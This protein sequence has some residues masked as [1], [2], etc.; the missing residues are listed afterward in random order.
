MMESNAAAQQRLISEPSSPIQRKPVK[1]TLD[2]PEP[3][4]VVNEASVI[5]VGSDSRTPKIHDVDV[6]IHQPKVDCKADGYH[7]GGQLGLRE[8]ENVLPSSGGRHAFV[9]LDQ[10]WWWNELLGVVLS[11]LAFA[12]IVI[13]LRR[14]EDRA[15]PDWPY[16]ISL[17]TFLALFVTIA[18]TGLMIS[19]S[20]GLSQQKWIWFLHI[21]RPLGDFQKYDNASRGGVVSGFKLLWTLKGR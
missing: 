1:P 17:N 7:N 15:L 21:K 16:N 18:I 10:N 19:V 13:V 6:Q 14:F 11:L 3:R 8:H 20:E 4:L 2:Q 5:S 12:A 9:R